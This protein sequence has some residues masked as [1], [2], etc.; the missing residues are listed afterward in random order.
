MPRPL[1]SRLLRDYTRPSLPI[2]YLPPLSLCGKDPLG[3][4]ESAGGL[5]GLLDVLVAGAPAEQAIRGLS[6]W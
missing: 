6:G 2:W 1:S 4:L 3:R 5:L